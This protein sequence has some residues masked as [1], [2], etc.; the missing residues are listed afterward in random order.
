VLLACEKSVA[1]FSW[2]AIPTMIDLSKHQR[3]Y[4]ANARAAGLDPG[5]TVPI[6]VPGP[7]SGLCSFVTTKGRPQLQDSLLAVQY[8]ACF[9]FEAAR[10][11][12][13]LVSR[14]IAGP[15]ARSSSQTS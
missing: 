5:Y 13:N 9:S 4:M 3:G 6:H 2:D 14:Q 8:L 1:P 15:V 10:G 12:S 7:A 11:K